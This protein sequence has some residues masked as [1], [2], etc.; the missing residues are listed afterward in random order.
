MF[1]LLSTKSGTSVISIRVQYNGGAEGIF[2]KTY[3]FDQNID[4]DILTPTYTPTTGIVGTQIP[5]IVSITDQYGNPIDTRR[6]EDDT[7]TLSVACPLPNDCSFVGYGYSYS[8]KPDSNGNITIPIQLGTK[9]GQTVIVMN[10]VQDLGQQVFM[11]DT[12]LSSPTSLTPNI[13]P[14]A[15]PPSTIPS[16]N[17]GT[18]VF[19]FS[20]KISDKYG[21]PVPNELI[22]VKMNSG[23]QFN[24]TT[25]AV[26]QT[27]TLPFGPRGSAQMINVTATVVS[28]PSINTTFQLAFVNANPTMSLFVIPLDMSSL[29][30]VP[31]TQADVVV[32][33]RDD[34][35]NPI[36]GQNILLTLNFTPAANWTANPYLASPYLTT[37]SG[38]T[39]ATGKVTTTFIP[40]SF[41]VS[42]APEK[43]SAK[44]TANWTQ[45]PFNSP[46]NVTITWSNSPY[47]NVYP[48]VSSDIVKVGDF[49]DVNLKVAINGKANT[50]PLTVVLDQDGTANMNRSISGSPTTME[51]DASN[52]SKTFVNLLNEAQTRIGMESFG[53]AP[54]EA[55][56]PVGFLE[57]PST[58]S[59]VNVELDKLANLKLTGGAKNY[60]YSIDNSLNKIRADGHP[61]NV[62]VVIFL[63]DGG[64]IL[65]DTEKENLKNKAIGDGSDAQ[66]IRIFTICYT[67]NANQPS[68]AVQLRYISEETGGTA[69]IA[70]NA[71]ELS[72]SFQE[73]LAIISELCGANTQMTISF[74]NIKIN[75]TYTVTNGLELYDYIPVNTT[76]PVGVM[77][78]PSTTINSSA[79]TSI[80]WPN[81]TQSVINQSNQFPNLQFTVGKVGLGKNWTTTF[82]LKAKKVGCYNLF[83]PGSEINF[84]TGTLPLTLPDVPICVNTTVNDTGVLQ[85]TLDV[86]NLRNVTSGPFAEF[87]PLQWNT[88]YNSSNPANP[89]NFAT[90]KIY[91]NI[92]GGP[93]IQFNTISVPHAD[94]VQPTPLS[95]P[96]QF[97]VRGI[98]RGSIINIWVHASAPDADDDD[99]YLNSISITNATSPYIILK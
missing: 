78:V 60:Y 13:Y 30:Y 87:V 85:G 34:L 83:G 56:P 81:N 99:E 37:Y 52:A 49:I 40:G 43:A 80:I 35:G 29:D 92:A 94:Y 61:E 27:S 73:I 68:G 93:W 39:D 12:K 64:S 77:S 84:G 79:R 45:D 51:Q 20:F 7:V 44:L 72:T 69:Y 25:N 19:T 8:A 9:S 90:E 91:Y 62:K 6:Y 75:K 11:I 98:P 95:S 57:I 63:S 58:F 89:A 33:V 76:A 2:D 22:L 31:P 5:F 10:P 36:Q 53:K 86:S 41:N 71:L 16:V 1:S 42:G 4:H 46:K 47:V 3:I 65:T 24:V 97:D 67:N 50:G 88:S 55:I 54:E 59:Q 26:G 15:I 17:V 96:L 82:R 74:D 18:G 48:V 38:T 32:S 66:L 21:N 14:A 70:R 28:K 23:E